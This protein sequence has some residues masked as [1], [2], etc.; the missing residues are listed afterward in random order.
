MPPEF[1][2]LLEVLRE[3]RALAQQK[4]TGFLFI[5]TEE[6]HS[7]MLRLSGG[8]VEDASF[9]M[10]R[11][12]EAIQRLSMVAAARARFQVDPAAA[13]G[14][15][16]LGEDA[17]HWLL[18]GFEQDLAARAAPASAA[19]PA[20]TAGI[21]AAGRAALEQVALLHFGPIGPMLCDE[22]FE[23]SPDPVRVI[24]I[25]SGNLATP[26]EAQRFQADARKAL[27]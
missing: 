21:D 22:A 8:R 3:L 26:A 25:L 5:V 11:N 23:Q 13:S 10:L 18:T 14:P 9:R 16:G 24:E 15:G 4:S 27:G 7:C 2:P 20:A 12:D 19:A 17:R 1:K 6:N